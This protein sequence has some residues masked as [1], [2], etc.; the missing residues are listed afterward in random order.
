MYLLEIIIPV[1]ETL[2]NFEHGKT[3]ISLINQMM[4]TEIHELYLPN[5]GLDNSLYSA[6]INNKYKTETTPNHLLFT[7]LSLK[8]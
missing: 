5:A 2:I 6:T 8:L 7:K 3:L 1:G 4:K